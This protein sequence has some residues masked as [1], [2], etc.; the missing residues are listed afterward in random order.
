MSRKPR[1]SKGLRRYIR[2]EKAGIR[3]KFGD[4]PESIEKVSALVARFSQKAVAKEPNL[5]KPEVKPKAEKL[6]KEP[7]AKPKKSKISKK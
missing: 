4:S 6:K 5:A 2:Q 1:L 7:K 3:R